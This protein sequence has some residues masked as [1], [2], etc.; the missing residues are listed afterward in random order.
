M[1]NPHSQ[2]KVDRDSHLTSMLCHVERE[3]AGS[4][5]R[6]EAQLPFTDLCN[7]EDFSCVL[8]PAGLST[9]ACVPKHP[10]LPLT[11]L[12]NLALREEMHSR[13]QSPAPCPCLQF[14]GISCFKSIPAS[15]MMGS[16][17][18]A[19][20]ANYLEISLTKSEPVLSG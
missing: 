3:E 6:T 17:H 4:P 20:M 7:L 1:S 14:A 2:E 5:V 9:A 12:P 11:P 10:A 8:P 19:V 16:Q 13:S 18:W 15:R